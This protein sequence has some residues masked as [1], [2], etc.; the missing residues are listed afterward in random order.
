M[1]RAGRTSRA[2]ATAWLP[3]TTTTAPDASAVLERVRASWEPQTEQ[4]RGSVEGAEAS[5]RRPC[6]L[7]RRW[8]KFGGRG[9]LLG[10][11]MRQL[12]RGVSGLVRGVA[13]PMPGVMERTRE[14]DD[15]ASL[16][17]DLARE[18]DDPARLVADP[19]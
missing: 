1:L 4:E 7:A 11:G 5:M 6:R 18:R 12:A 9:G 16:V 14:R 13:R 3:H 8:A 2:C 15:P 17:A 19:A 10:R